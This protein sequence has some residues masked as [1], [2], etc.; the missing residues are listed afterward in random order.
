MASKNLGLF[1][2]FVWANHKYQVWAKHPV[3]IMGFLAPIERM[4][5]PVWRMKILG[6]IMVI[7]APM[8]L[9]VATEPHG[10]HREH[11]ARTQAALGLGLALPEPPAALGAPEVSGLAAGAAA[12]VTPGPPMIWGLGTTHVF[13]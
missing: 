3:T 9:M 12:G 4:A 11:V 8:V 5:D 1:P 6:Q 2:D 10:L 13:G 7:A